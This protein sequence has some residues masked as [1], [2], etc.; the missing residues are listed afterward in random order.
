MNVNSHLFFS[1][2]LLKLIFMY[3]KR[4]QAA[5]VGTAALLLLPRGTALTTRG[6]FRPTAASPT[7]DNDILLCRFSLDISNQ[8]RWSPLEVLQ[9]NYLMQLLRISLPLCSETQC[10]WI[11]ELLDHRANKSPS[12]RS[13]SKNTWSQTNLKC[14][15]FKRVHQ[16]RSWSER[17]LHDLSR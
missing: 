17:V 15:M 4:H 16:A 8:N 11:H 3:I 6:R 1:N 5:L 14:C 10:L 12:L 2:L 9:L 13:W 7:K